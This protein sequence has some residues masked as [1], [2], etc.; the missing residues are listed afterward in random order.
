MFSR[1]HWFALYL[2]MRLPVLANHP[3]SRHRYGPHADMPVRTTNMVHK[4]SS[5]PPLHSVYIIY[6]CVLNWGR[7]I[8]QRPWKSTTRPKTKWS[9]DVRRVSLWNI[10]IQIHS[11]YICPYL[12]LPRFNA[13]ENF[14]A[15]DSKM[16]GLHG[17]YGSLESWT[18]ARAARSAAVPRARPFLIDKRFGTRERDR[19]TWDL[20]GL[21][22]VSAIQ[23]PSFERKEVS[24]KNQPVPV[25]F[26]N[27]SNHQTSFLIGV[28][29]KYLL[30]RIWPSIS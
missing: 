26:Q 28:L 19:W 10:V 21:V 2:K 14:Q 6:A 22:I 23:Q 24:K 3:P 1:Y 12:I 15:F 30:K 8:Y 29:Y 20:L 16:F 5:V 18:I 11:P 13:V 7:H 4:I 17:F 25:A 27:T 9:G